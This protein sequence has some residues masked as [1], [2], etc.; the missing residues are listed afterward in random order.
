MASVCSGFS[1]NIGTLLT[2]KDSQEPGERIVKTIDHPLLEWNDRVLGDGDV[3]GAD[4]RA[5]SGDV[6][7]AD[8]VLLLQV[9]EPV[10]GIDGIHLE[11]RVVQQKTRADEL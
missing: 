4:G 5:A 6:A 9:R 2:A 8:A 11:R 10:F 1:A 7:V 3:F